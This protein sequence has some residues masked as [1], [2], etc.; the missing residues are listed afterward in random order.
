VDLTDEALV[1]SFRKTKDSSHF[2]SLVRRYQNRIYNA[3]YRVLGNTEEAEEVVQETYIRVHHNLDKFRRQ[4]SFGAWIFRIAHNICVDL[5]RSKKRHRG[6]QLLSF[7]PQTTAD[8]EESSDVTLNVVSQ[9][10]DEG[11]C[12]AEL[13]DYN[14]QTEIIQSSLNELPEPQ[15]MVVVLHDIEGFS[16]QEISE[17]V[18]TSIGTVR[19]RLHYG[20]LKLRELLDPYFSSN[21]SPVSR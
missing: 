11:P 3:A 1:E 19:S 6:I 9:V 7:D 5:L 17:I 20:R 12:P 15:R 2:K 4:S 16:Y 10:A 18:G 13:L 14:E 21:M 8:G